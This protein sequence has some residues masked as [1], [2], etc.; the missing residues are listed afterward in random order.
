MNLD[1]VQSEFPSCTSR[2]VLRLVFLFFVDP[3][4]L[5]DLNVASFQVI[6]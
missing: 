1:E 4:R 3:T 6:F 5:N 2:T